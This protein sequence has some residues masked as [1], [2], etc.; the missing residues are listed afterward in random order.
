MIPETILKEIFTN[1]MM[2]AILLSCENPM[3]PTPEEEKACA[4]YAG[5]TLANILDEWKEANGG[6]KIIVLEDKGEDED[7]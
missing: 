5:D 6:Q 7:E 4:K 3:H 1:L 2:M